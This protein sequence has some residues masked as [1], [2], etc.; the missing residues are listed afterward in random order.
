MF[1]NVIGIS[2]YNKKK[3]K[4]PINNQSVRLFFIAIKPQEA[5]FKNNPPG[6]PLQQARKT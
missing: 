1:F 2:K 5:G 3:K 6:L 4:T